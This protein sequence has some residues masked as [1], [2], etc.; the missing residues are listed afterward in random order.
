MAHT[1]LYDPRFTFNTVDLSDH[2]SEMEL[3][4]ST[5]QLEDIAGGDTVVTFLAGLRRFG[6]TISGMGDYA[7]GEVDAT[8]MTAWS[9]RSAV[10]VTLGPD[11]TSAISTS[12]PE[13]QF[14]GFVAEYRPSLRM[15]TENRWTL[16]IAPTTD[17]TR[18]VTP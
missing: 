5:D 8:I 2:V 7:A 15:N 6:G 12:N 14:S 16:R 18:D 3:E 1:V 10:A 13:Y 9:A 4:V 17:L 11:K